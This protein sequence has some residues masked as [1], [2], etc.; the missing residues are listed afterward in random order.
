MFRCPEFNVESDDGGKK[1][2]RYQEES[3]TQVYFI[4]NKN[5]LKFI[6]CAKTP[7]SCLLFASSTS[8]MH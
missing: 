3:K 4:S 5:G 8:E 7:H 1:D 2:D 6:K